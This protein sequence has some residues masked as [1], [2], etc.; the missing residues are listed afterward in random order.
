MKRLVIIM[1]IFFLVIAL[2]DNVTAQV[3]R[4]ARSGPM[5]IGQPPEPQNIQADPRMGLFN[6]TAEKREELEKVHKA[7]LDDTVKLRNDIRTKMTELD[8]L[9]RT[10]DPDVNRAKAIQKEISDLQA[11]LA[12]KSLELRLEILKINPDARYGIGFG[13]NM[14]RFDPGMGFGRR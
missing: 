11:E 4:R 1:A 5:M 7:F 10:D 8:N 6:M 13:R 12:Q 3:F 14:M 9:L 2:S